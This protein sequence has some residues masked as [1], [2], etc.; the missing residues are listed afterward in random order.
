MN[1]KFV[2][3]VVIGGVY[4]VL[5]IL[6]AWTTPLFETPDET[7]HFWYV[8]HLADGNGLAVVTA[9]ERPLWRQEGTQPPLYYLLA[10]AA[11][12][13]VDTTNAADVIQRNPHA[14]IGRADLP[15]DRNSVLPV[16]RAP[17]QGAAEA[18]QR[19]RWLSVLLGLVTVLSIYG[20]A[21]ETFPGDTLL[22]PAA[23]LFAAFIPQFLF[24][25][26]SI[27]ND[28]LIVALSSLALWRLVHWLRRPPRWGDLLA[29][30]VIGGLAALAKLSGLA[31]IAFIVAVVAVRALARRSARDLLAWS[32]VLLVL[33][34]AVAGPFYWRNFALYGDP[35]A[36]DIHLTLS[37]RRTPRPSP[38]QL[39]L[40]LDSV[41]HSIWGVFGWFNVPVPPWVFAVYDALSIAA[42][43]GL[44]MGVW[45]RLRRGDEIETQRRKGA[46]EGGQASEPLS[47][48]GRGAGVRD[49]S[50][51]ALLLAWA[52]VVFV[53]LL[54]WMTLIKS[55]QGRLL[56]PA[57]GALAV[58]A[59]WGLSQ[60]APRY[61]GIVLGGVL[62]AMGV[63]A[64]AIPFLVIAPAYAAPPWLPD[65]EAAAPAY[66]RDDVFGGQMRLLGYD[67]GGDIAPGGLLPVTLDWQ[68]AAP[69]DTNY[70][71]FA[72]LVGSEPGGGRAAGTDTYP[73]LGS[74][75]TQGWPVG[76]VLR[77]TLYI[78]I[79]E[80]VAAPR[81]YPLVVGVYDRAK[82]TRLAVTRDGQAAGDS[83]AL[84]SVFVRPDGWSPPN[85][86]AVVLGGAARLLGYDLGA[87]TAR[88]GDTLPLTLYWRA[89]A[90]LPADY[91]VFVHVG[92]GESLAAQADA[93]P[94]AGRAPTSGWRA[95]QTVADSH[96][97][98]IRPDAAPGVYS[99]RVGLYDPATGARLPV[100]GGGAGDAV[101]LGTI[102]V[103]R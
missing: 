90:P 54:R 10:A 1:T 55:A 88:P 17:L 7:W 29:L 82:D 51:L 97:L 2:S 61:R 64:A 16:A 84:G 76:P 89:D 85:P 43:V 73:G 83:V 78:P 26:G 28:N 49:V 63:L 77:D 40:E 35:L 9:D 20:L 98:R 94:L 87:T 81:S 67:V 44:G 19:A 8:K 30:G 11:I 71:V 41:R 34:L 39:F 38:W 72:Q 45:R 96:T 58:L 91:T 21:R 23:A 79:G 22:P 100:T 57:L 60:L 4:L 5:A 15:G 13:G 95:G 59:V 102:T 70:S 62:A 86:Q 56:F 33:P 32:A 80:K 3:L 50:I 18:A 65:I 52:A 101:E 93:P 53:S 31:L 46:K 69:M 37:G 48:S 6:Y 47:R 25:S 14:N 74:A 66:P 68:A 36:L 92:D 12:R 99:V 27:N 103:G 42:L 24:L 75:P